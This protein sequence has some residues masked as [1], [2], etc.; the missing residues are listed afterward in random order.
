M[1][2]GPE[3][4][5]GHLKHDGVPVPAQLKP[6]MPRLFPVVSIGVHISGHLVE[7]SQVRLTSPIT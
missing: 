2:G 5:E 1:A 3:R 7:G 4:G 6:A